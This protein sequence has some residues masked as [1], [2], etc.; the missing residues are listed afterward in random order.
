MAVP[1]TAAVCVA[2]QRSHAD[3]TSRMSR[4]KSPHLP[5]DEANGT[6]AGGDDAKK[7][8]D[9][10]R[11]AAADDAKRPGDAKEAT[12]DDATKADEPDAKRQATDAAKAELAA[13]API[14]GGPKPSNVIEEGRI[15]FVYRCTR[16][17]LSPAGTGLSGTSARECVTVWQRLQAEA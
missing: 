6:E 4:S 7:Q 11:E 16:V 2:A 13:D 12:A 14:G 1:C 15:Y 5:A 17:V 10:A 8:G 3:L 9:D